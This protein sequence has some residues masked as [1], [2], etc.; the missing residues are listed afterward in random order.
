MVADVNMQLLKV[1]SF[2]ITNLISLWV[3]N[4]GPGTNELMWNCGLNNLIASISITV[5]LDVTIT[6]M[7]LCGDHIRKNSG[8][9]RTLVGDNHHVDMISKVVSR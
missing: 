5:S 2:E 8:A 6:K 3:D 1:F 4:F 7:M 9:K